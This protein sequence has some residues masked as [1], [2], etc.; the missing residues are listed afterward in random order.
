MKRSALIVA[1]DPALRAWIGNNVSIRWPQIML[2]FSKLANAGIYLDRA[3][4]ERYQLIV[5]RLSSMSFAEMTLC[6]LLIRIL[7]GENRPEILLIA[8]NEEQLRAARSTKLKEATFML[9]RDMNVASFQE[10]LQEIS[11]CT[12]SSVSATASGGPEIP[13]FVI[14][15][16]LAGTYT[17]TIYIA[18]SQA[19]GRDVALKITELE[20]SNKTAVSQYSLRD[21]FSVLRKLGGTHVAQAYEYGEMD[22][23]AYLALEYFPKGSIGQYLNESGRNSSRFEIMLAV[24]EALDFVHGAGFLHLDLKPNNILVRE[25]GMPAL[26]DFGI[27][28]RILVAEHMERRSFSMGSPY[29]MS[30]EQCLGMPLDVRSDIYSFGAVWYYVF[31]GRTPFRGRTFEEIQRSRERVGIPSLGYALRHYQPI[32]DRTLAINRDDR[33]GS[34]SE[35]M[36]ALYDC[37]ASATGVH[38]KLDMAEYV[39]RMNLESAANV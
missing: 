35:L 25:N 18:H 30:P 28:S 14:R 19:L 13:G 17:S 37:S 27:S 20:T 2:E 5:V 26:I 1:D 8:D 39:R 4:I 22:G 12:D 11:A 31:T 6:I 10:A 7:N 23:L 29:F 34:V 33:Y 21:E 16:A 15:E 38:R 24:A 9:A 3:R 32:V 36:D